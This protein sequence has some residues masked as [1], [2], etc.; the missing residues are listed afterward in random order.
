MAVKSCVDC[1]SY[2]TSE[3][4]QRVRFKKAVGAPMC[5]RFG[6]VLGR[7]GLDN[8]QVAIKYGNSCPSHKE[9]IPS[10]P[11]SI[12]PKLVSPDV[13]ILAKGETGTPCK[14]CTGCS[15]LL[16][17]D[18]THGAFGWPVNV[19]KAKGTAVFLPLS[20]AKGCPYA[21][22]GAPTDDST[23]L[24]V[25]PEFDRHFTVSDD[26]VMSGLMPD[27][28]GSGSL[29]PTT[30][31][32]EGPV[33]EEDEGT[34][35]AWFGVKN[36]HN[37]EEIFLPIFEPDFFSEEERAL[38]PQTGDDEHP[39]LYV[40]H[41]GLLL[42]FAVET[43]KLDES[44]CLVGAAGNGKTEFGRYAAWRMQVP[45]RRLSITEFTEPEEFL[46]S[47][48]YDPAKGTYF[49]PGRL[50]QAWG[51][52]GVLVSDEF[53]VGPDAIHQAYRPLTDNSKQ[54]VIDDAVFDRN[55]YCFHLLTQNPAWEMKNVGTKPLA[56]ADGNRLSFAWV[57]EP[58]A[59]LM[60]HIIKERCKVDGYDVPEDTLK[61]ISA[62]GKDIREFSEQGIFPGTWGIRQEVK[63]ARKTAH[64][65]IVTAYKRAVLDNV[66]PE[67]AKLVV[68]AIESH[69]P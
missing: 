16:T 19:C 1:P 15:N 33:S 6:Y 69:I 66:D 26:I 23:G 64:Y 65:D 62:I 5:G 63:V 57:P 52:P 21:S 36:P 68:S 11:V 42:T 14:T 12:S 43:W 13:D 39:E 45:F 2:L 60:R 51:R 59:P 58:P 44:L 50:P 25:L 10:S 48:E 7:P 37:G 34:I 3:E 4:D 53:N 8:E 35:R 28:E 32:T 41:A 67:V 38:I 47:S 22:P 56:D 20:E 54:L 49:K 17:S 61:L 31:P 24:T 40:D 18:A 9:V 55:A 29:E 30:M 27:F 46:G